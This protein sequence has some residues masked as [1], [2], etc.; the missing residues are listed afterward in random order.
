MIP[1]Q[2]SLRISVLEPPYIALDLTEHN[3]LLRMS[4]DSF[5]IMLITTDIGV[6]LIT[7]QP[8]LAV[9][10]WVICIFELKI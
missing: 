4:L 1:M 9:G 2:F 5:D 7:S 3:L 10:Y 6:I 8:G